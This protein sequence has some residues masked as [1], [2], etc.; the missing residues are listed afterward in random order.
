MVI[1][2]RQLLQQPIS[3]ETVKKVQG[4]LSEEQMLMLFL[5]TNEMAGDNV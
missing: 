4:L 5:N 3:V 2:E 1:Y